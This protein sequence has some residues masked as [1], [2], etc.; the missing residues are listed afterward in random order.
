MTRQLVFIP[1]SSEEL[2]VL[3]GR[4]PV[5]HRR[6]Y[7]VTPDL[8]REL[9]YT[10]DMAEEAE[11][12]ALVLASIAG[13]TEYG[14]RCVVVAEVDPTLVEPGEDSLN[15]ECLLTRCPHTAMTAWFVD[16]PGVRTP[17]VR[18]GARPG[19]CPRFRNCSPSTTCCGTTSRSTAGS[20]P[21]AEPSG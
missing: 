1:I 4:I 14:E 7:T 15:G 17:M 21:T 2:D 20:T 5:E 16:A 6:A 3:T 18:K 12:A 10:A 11:S 13:L 9:D 19:T 8:L